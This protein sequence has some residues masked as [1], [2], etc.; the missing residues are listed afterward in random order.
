[1]ARQEKD[2][3]DLA[4]RRG[5]RIAEIY[6]ENDTSA[7][8]RRKVR[9]PDG[10]TA[11]RVDRPAFR[12]LIGDLAAGTVTGLIAYDLD[13]VARDPRDLEDL[14]DVVEGHKIP[15][16]AVTGSLDLST[17]AGI[18]M[19]RI[20]VA[21]ANKSSRDTSRRVARKHLE[22][23]ELGKVGGGG[24]RSYGYARD[25][26]TILESE[27]AIIRELA[28]RIIGG[29]TL[30]ALARDLTAR[31]IS[32]VRAGTRWNARSVHSVVS[33]ARNA[34]LREHRGEVIGPAVWPS[35]IDPDTWTQVKAALAERARGSNNRMQR[36]LTGVLFCGRHGC[37]NRLTGALGP[38]GRPAV[39][40]CAKATGGCGRLNI[41]APATEDVIGRLI[42]TYLSRP[43]VLA[44]L[45]AATSR[46]NTQQARKEAAAD[47][48]QLSELAGLWGG[49]K[50]STKEYL[51]ARKEIESRLSRSK[52]IL[53]AST[54]LGV[55]ALLASADISTA[56][57]NMADPHD[58]REVARIVF[59]DGIKVMPITKRSFA[60]D[61]ERLQPIDWR[62]P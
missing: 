49:R 16:A 61:P 46:E 52:A 59:P 2:C 4:H 22:L 56:W 7:F 48:E 47:E 29:E 53:R 1:V 27:A 41:A 14:I 62:A 11:L 57:G 25:G 26:M 31:G 18:T 54:P 21:I 3:R 30:S 24:I 6:A 9:L 51:A 33:K 10:T 28:N 39:Y 8:K 43:D 23:A 15:T 12:K 38:V 13:R 36:W 42:V 5:W 60:F 20:A 37:G 45:A 40:R 34:G 19:A 50:I 17:D 35:I 32:T 44:D 55:R 58:R